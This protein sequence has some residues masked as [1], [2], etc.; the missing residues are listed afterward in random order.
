MPFTTKRWLLSNADGSFHITGPENKQERSFLFVLPIHQP[1]S[2]YTSF[3]F[4]MM[5][6]TETLSV[7]RQVLF[8]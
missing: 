5:R 1:R 3:Q 2:A 8:S 6:H 4:P 7:S